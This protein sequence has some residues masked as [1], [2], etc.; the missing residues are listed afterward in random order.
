MTSRYVK[1]LQRIDR[2]QW[3]PYIRWRNQQSIKQTSVADNVPLFQVFAV[4]IID[5]EFYL[6]LFGFTSSIKRMIENFCTLME[7]NSLI[8]MT[9]E[10]CKRIRIVL[11]TKAE[12]LRTRTCTDSGENM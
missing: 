2:A 11:L 1:R 6:F 10:L 9:L 4:C 5:A 8:S 7:R 12:Q 3:I